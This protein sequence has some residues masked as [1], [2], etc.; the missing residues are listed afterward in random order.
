M[1]D[2]KKFKKDKIIRFKRIYEFFADYFFIGGISFLL[3]NKNV[4]TKIKNSIFPPKY[5][6][7]GKM[8]IN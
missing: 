1:E 3:F 5:T 7:Y 4:F 2:T 6:R 8:L